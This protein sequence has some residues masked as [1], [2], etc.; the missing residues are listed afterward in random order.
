MQVSPRFHTIDDEAIEALV[1]RF[2]ARVRSDA[3]L[4]PIFERE[5]SNWAPHLA[6]MRNFWASVLL[7]AGRYQGNPVRVHANLPDIQPKH[8]ARWLEH[9]HDTAK[10]LFASPERERICH[11]AALIGAALQARIC[12]H[13]A[14]LGRP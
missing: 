1:E 4:G 2:Y 8:F 14:V 10:E 11:K 6:T 13:G 3:V 12:G 7:R 5:I 9:F